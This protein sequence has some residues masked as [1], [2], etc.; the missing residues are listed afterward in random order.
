M[1][2]Q[3]EDEEEIR[4][5]FWQNHPQFD[6]R[7]YKGQNHPSQNNYNATIRSAWCE[8]IDYLQKDGQISE[9]LAD[10]VTL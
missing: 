5:A 2:T 8:W 1:K 4:E 9:E 6:S 7:D 10:K 3:Y